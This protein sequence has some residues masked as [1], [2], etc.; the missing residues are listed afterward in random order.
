MDERRL[1]RRSRVNRKVAGVCGGFGEFFDLDPVLV[2]V[3]WTTLTIVPGALIFG[4]IAYVVAWLMIPETAPSSE[5]LVVASDNSW[6]SKRLRRSATDSK[7]AGVCGG[8]AEYFGI[9]PTA[10]RVLWVLL[11]ILPGAVICGL[12]AYVVAWVV[13]P[14]SPVS[15]PAAS[16]P[17]AAASPQ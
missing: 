1:L 12:I 7:I 11:S 15:A 2:R 16:V 8:I 6:R 10:V 3:V 9:D 4:M 17:T 13:M 5:P 14:T